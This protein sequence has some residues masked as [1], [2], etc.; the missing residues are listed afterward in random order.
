MAGMAPMA[1]GKTI[2]LVGT[3][4]GDACLSICLV[5][6]NDRTATPGAATPGTAVTPGTAATLGTA[7]PLSLTGEAQ[8]IG[9]GDM[10]RSTG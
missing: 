8:R 10:P 4:S 9:N 2:P 3:C 6:E 1:P 5:G 7:A